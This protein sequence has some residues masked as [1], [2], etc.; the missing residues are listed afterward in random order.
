MG[1]QSGK[2]RRGHVEAQLNQLGPGVQTPPWGSCHWH[3]SLSFCGARPYQQLTPA[4]PGEGEAPRAQEGVT[5]LPVFSPVNSLTPFFPCRERWLRVV[6]EVC[7]G[8]PRLRKPGSE[9]RPGVGVEH[10]ARRSEQR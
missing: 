8:C 3:S 9:L 1:A 6:V 5:S 10:T 7:L 4:T 2:S